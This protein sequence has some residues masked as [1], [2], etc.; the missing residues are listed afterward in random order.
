VHIFRFTF[1]GG[2]IA[3]IAEYANTVTYAKLAGMP[4]G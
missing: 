1:R 4:I 3:H 2:Q